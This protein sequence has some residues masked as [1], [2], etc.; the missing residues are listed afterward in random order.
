MS[1][2][3][4]ILKC[5]SRRLVR[6]VQLLPFFLPVIEFEFYNGDH[7]GTF[8]FC[9]INLFFLFYFRASLICFRAIALFLDGTKG[10]KDLNVCYIFLL[11]GITERNYIWFFFHHVALIISYSILFSNLTAFL[12]LMIKIK[13]LNEMIF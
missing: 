5:L 10:K 1:F 11:S 2:S 3:L 13:L 7:H 8:P 12:H 4:R 6:P 9:A